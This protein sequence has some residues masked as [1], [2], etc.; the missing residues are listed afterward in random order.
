MNRGCPK[1]LAHARSAN[2]QETRRGGID[3][4]HRH[5][6]I[7]VSTQSAEGSSYE[8]T[9][10]QS[11]LQQN[12]ACRLGYGPVRLLSAAVTRAEINAVIAGKFG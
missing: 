7:V 11:T 10:K 2:P 5:P 6:L 4:F 1:V 8:T 9:L 3:Q 12:H